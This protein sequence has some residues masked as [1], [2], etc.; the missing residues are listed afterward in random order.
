MRRSF[1]CATRAVVLAAQCICLQLWTNTCC[2]HQLHGQSPDEIDAT[3]KV[4]SGHVPGAI[5][6]AIRKMEHELGI[7]SGQ[8]DVSK[9]RFL[10]RLLYCAG[11]ADPG[12]GEPT[13]WGEHE[14]DY[15][16]FARQDVSLVPNPEEVDAVK[17]VTAAE[18]KAMMRTESGLRWSPWFRIIAEHFLFRWWGDLD[19]VLAG[20]EHADRATIHR[21]SCS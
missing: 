19:A 18:L 4:A 14:L 15:I 1:L 17:Y 2:S 16:L 20:A 6:A 3:D 9:I 11:D 7:L 5:A 13:G 21:L 10:T 12:T 8:L